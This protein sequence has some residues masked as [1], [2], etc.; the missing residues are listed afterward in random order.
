MKRLV[1]AL[2]ALLGLGAIGAIALLLSTRRMVVEG[3]SMEPEFQP[4]DRVLV[5]KLAYLRS[6]PARGDVVVVQRAGDAS[7]HLKRIAFVPGDEVEA[8]SGRRRLGPGEYWLLGDNPAESTD[9]RQLGP[10]RREEIAGKV[11]FK[12]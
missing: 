2:A 7:P 8:G 9:S 12:Y 10:A 5:N 1:P 4:G 3:R 11:L 6:A